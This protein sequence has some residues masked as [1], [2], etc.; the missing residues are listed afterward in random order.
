MRVRDAETRNRDA[1]ELDAH[2]LR[3]FITEGQVHGDGRA[4]WLGRTLDTGR[5]STR[6]R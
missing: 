4:Y 5:R 6:S 1:A 3:R 2:D